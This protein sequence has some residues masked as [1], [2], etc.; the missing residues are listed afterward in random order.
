MSLQPEA[1]GPVPEGTARVARAAF[2]RGNVY[3][4]MRDELGAVYEDRDFA[5][6]FPARG[7]PAEAPWRLALVSA[8][9]FAEG[10]SDR[11]AAEAVRGRI[12]W[13]Y[14]LGLELT[15]PGFDA[16]V[17]SEFR[18][19]L[20]AGGAE[21]LLLEAMLA[22]FRAA[23][24]LKARGR[25]RTDS[26]H[27]LA[28]IR[29]LNRLECAGETL[30]HALN[31][32]AAAAPDW[33]RP[34]LD[35]AWADR[36]G[37]R[38][39]DFRLPKGQPERRALAEAIG[40]DGFRLLGDLAA[41]DAPPGLRA[42]PAVETLRRVWAQEYEP[43]GPGGAARW[44]ED[45]ELAPAAQRINSPH[46]PDARC[47]A[48]RSTR[49][50]GYKAHLTETC[51][52]GGP[53]LITHAETT[54]ATTSDKDLAPVIHGA[55]AAKGLLPREHLLDGGYVDSELLVA[56]RAEHGVEVIGLVPPDTHW[57]AR[58]GA[59]FAAS[60]FAVDWEARRARCPAGRT[61]TKWSETR[62]TRGN[63][64]INI[65]FARADCLACPDRAR[66]TTARDGP[67][68]ITVRP[69]EQHEAL[70]AARRRQ[71]TAA[72]K[73]E[74]G[75][76]AGVEGTIS[77]GVRACGL[78][79]ARYLGLARTRLQHVLTAAGLNLRRLGAWWDDAPLARTRRAPFL[80]LATAA[81]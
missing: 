15:D 60:R 16:S 58:A 52:P 73:E 79:R 5:A 42:L 24:L 2:P 65:R 70:L 37:A 51:D 6:L 20:V 41:E 56:S 76:R 32:L 35:P 8:M 13:K 26:T 61:S 46:D 78:R 25:Q 14:A 80:A 67:R 18:S 55:L 63:P 22:R 53:H 43:P 71:A 3:L 27:V 10:L 39:E 31:G 36:Y 48:K 11:Q 72:F 1:I 7:Q 77:Q 69:R 47:G 9:Q 54:P 30:R 62:D 33:L 66:C 19:R 74:Y 34:R 68:E 28:S 4:R 17:L 23:G 49:W 44:R 57:Q 81:A 59:G 64:V 21:R 38:F 75:A 29:W 45:A 40:A 12:D 50:T